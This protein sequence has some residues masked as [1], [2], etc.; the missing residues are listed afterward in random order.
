M[1]TLDSLRLL[2][3][4]TPDL[5]KRLADGLEYRLAI[6]RKIS[7]RGPL[8]QSIFL[9]LRADSFWYGPDIL[10]NDALEHAIFYDPL[11]LPTS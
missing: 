4:S 7:L 6:H 10:H 8:P 9:F 5:C 1:Q 3:T 11:Y 2:S